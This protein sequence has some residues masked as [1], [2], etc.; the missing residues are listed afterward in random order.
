MSA[1]WITL[2]WLLSGV[3]LVV[4]EAMIPGVFVMFL[5]LAA[6]V[7]AGLRWA[8]GLEHLG[9]SFLLW[10]ILS[11]VFVAG[12][13]SM[14]MRL[15]GKGEQRKAYVNDQD[16][17]DSLGA[18]VEVVKACTD[19]DSEGRIRY[20]GTTWSAMTMGGRLEVGSKARLVT[21][22]NLVWMI[23][24]A[25]AFEELS[26]P[27]VSATD[28]RAMQAFDE[29]LMSQSQS[30]PQHNSTTSPEE[31]EVEAAAHRS[32]RTPASQRRSP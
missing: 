29:A 12:F 10:G 13:R 25:D 6:V 22:D 21:R 15:V 1:E 30:Q 16:E 27:R 26:G 24:P 7:I 17:V 9:I 5:G 32:K 14:V 2:I 4:S 19:T 11:A 31:D 20:Q 23:E 18:E 28:Q 8:V 3:A